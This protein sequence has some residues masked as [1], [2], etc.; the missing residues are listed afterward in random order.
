MRSGLFALVLLSAPV[1]AQVTCDQ[2]GNSTY[3]NGSLQQQ[4]SMQSPNW[5]QYQQTPDIAGAIQKGRE[6]RLRNQLMQAQIDEANARAEASR[7]QVAQ[8][9]VQATQV[10]PQSTSDKAPVSEVAGYV[11]AGPHSQ[12]ADIYLIAAGNAFEWA[13]VMLAS[14][15]K[16]QLYCHPPTLFLNAQNYRDIADADIAQLPDVFKDPQMHWRMEYVLLDGLKKT[17]PC[18]AAQFEPP[19]QPK[20][21]AAKHDK[22]R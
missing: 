19:M 10:P 2:V 8:A 15:K 22:S 20:H 9:Q 4:P 17:F 21:G 11:A 18:P 1:A 14:D 12:G 6:D 16:P 3:C 13:N 5:L 7:A